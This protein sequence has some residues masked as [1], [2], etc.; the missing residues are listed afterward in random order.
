VIHSA[1][2]ITLIQGDAPPVP[3][4]TRLITKEFALDLSFCKIAN[5]L[6]ILPLA[7]LVMQEIP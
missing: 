1:I 4:D 5:L 7:F 6:S 3:L 2:L